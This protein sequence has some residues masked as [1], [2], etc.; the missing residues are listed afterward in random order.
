M[1]AC[2]GAGVVGEGSKV[3]CPRG[4]AEGL[5]LMWG[6]GVL[7]RARHRILDTGMNVGCGADLGAM[8]G[9]ELC[10]S[11][12][13][14]LVGESRFVAPCWGGLGWVLPVQ[15]T[16]G[17]LGTRGWLAGIDVG[18]VPGLVARDAIDPCA[19]ASGGGSK[20]FL[21]IL[22]AGYECGA[23]T[24]FVARGARGPCSVIRYG[25]AENG[26]RS[27]KCSVVREA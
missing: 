18:L 27:C 19:L 25:G 7:N 2:S 8:T 1:E 12:R 16:A 21:A 4:C 15:G 11:G 6:T 9:I 3:V 14:C 5:L 10:S 17:C 13:R 20:G 24:E 22:E 23:G 26:G